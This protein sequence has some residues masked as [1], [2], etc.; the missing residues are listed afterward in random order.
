MKSPRNT[1]TTGQADQVVATDFTFTVRLHP[2][3]PD[4]NRARAALNLAIVGAEHCNVVVDGKMVA[5][6]P[7][8]DAE[9][10]D[11]HHHMNMSVEITV[12]ADL[13]RSGRWTNFRVKK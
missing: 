3:E 8:H 13:T 4:I 12:L 6:F 11:A 9:L 2:Q 1:K 10:G 7:E 5:A